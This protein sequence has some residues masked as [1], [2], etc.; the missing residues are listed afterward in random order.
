MSVFVVAVFSFSHKTQ[1]TRLVYSE[2]EVDTWNENE[3]RQKLIILEFADQNKES[4]VYFK[5]NEDLYIT[6]K[7]RMTLSDLNPQ[8]FFL[9]SMQWLIQV[10]TGVELVRRPFD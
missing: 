7:L 1:S 2:K 9:S 10:K 6:L 5:D 3:G 4:W 8:E